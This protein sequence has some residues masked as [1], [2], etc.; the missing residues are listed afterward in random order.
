M[1]NNV[2]VVGGTGML[3]YPVVRRLCADG[4]AVRVMT[5]NLERA[6]RIFGDTV[7]LVEG[8]VT[9]PQTL[10][11]PMRNCDAVY[12]NLS[13]K[14]DI[15]SYDTVE[16]QGAANLAR[17]AAERRL[18]RIAM[19]SGLGVDDEDSPHPY[20]SAKVAAERA[21]RECGVPYTI[22]RCCWFMESLPLYI[23]GN[24]AFLVGKQP[25]PI[26]WIAATDYSAMVSNALRTDEAINKTFHIHG[27]DKMTIRE[28]LELFCAEVYPNVAISSLPLWMLSL[29]SKF[30]RRSEMKGFLDFMKYFEHHSEPVVTD[31]SD[32]ILGPALTSLRDWTVEYKKHMDK[33]PETVAK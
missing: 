28:A 26:S 14:M 27:I 24:K 1:V 31:D 5:H 8:N 17:I 6:R 7:S 33:E 25:H 22:F 20:I 11:E 32:R 12:I 13:A 15:D 29:M 9:D 3:G 18:E 16:H 23:Q 10:S 2:L 30:S 19:I 21:L 4:Y